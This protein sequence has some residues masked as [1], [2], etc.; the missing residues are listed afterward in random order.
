M[1]AEQLGIELRRVGSGK[2][3]T[4]GPGEAILSDWMAENAYVIW[5]CCEEPWLLEE[6]FISQMCLP[7]NL[8]Q[9]RRNAFHAVLSG[10]RSAA[11][12]RARRLEIRS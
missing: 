11:K 5:H 9:N 7:L 10:V 1:L 3:M 4:F 8:D 6:Q 2:R 12:D